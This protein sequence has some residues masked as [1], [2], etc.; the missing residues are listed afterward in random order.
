MVN[1]IFSGQ[2]KYK[3]PDGWVDG[4]GFS[5]GFI[6]S[7]PEDWWYQTY[8]DKSIMDLCNFESSLQIT[9]FLDNLDCSI[10]K[11]KNDRINYARSLP[12]KSETPLYKYNNL[13]L[14][15]EKSFGFKRSYLNEIYF[16]E[17]SI[18][19]PDECTASMTALVYTPYE[20]LHFG[21][22]NNLEFSGSDKQFIFN[23]LGSFRH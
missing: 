15:G 2:K 21:I 19:A 13:S 10:L 12:I 4:G 8:D 16:V 14:Y 5:W 1:S 11:T 6:F 20:I 9:L 17:Y 18:L 22:T 3:R 7:Y 23:V